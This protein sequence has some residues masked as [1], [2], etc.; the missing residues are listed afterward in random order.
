[1]SGVNVTK[2]S[3]GNKKEFLLTPDHYVAIAQTF[4]VDDANIEVVDGRNI[5]KAGT[6]WPANNGTAKGILVHDVDVT[7]GPWN[8]SI[9]IH[10]FIKSEALPFLPS[11]EAAAAL[12]QIYFTATTDTDISTVSTIAHEANGA[13][14]V[15]DVADTTFLA[16][17]SNAANWD[18]DVGTTGL[19]LAGIVKTSG[20]RATFTFTGTADG[21]TLTIQALRGAVT[22]GNPSN[23][24]SI[25]VP[26]S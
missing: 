9:I 22:N 10:G 3:Y 1:M 4:A 2:K 14:V 17:C 24:I 21:G 18:I 15:V 7:D 16:G 12:K 25:T 20:T 8:G 19:T 26:N 6:I 5:I 11:E 13:T 23:V